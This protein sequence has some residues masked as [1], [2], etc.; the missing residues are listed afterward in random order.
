VESSL[1]DGLPNRAAEL[2]DNHLLGFAYHEQARKSG[3][4]R[5]NQYR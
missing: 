5:Q 3:N 2:R 4:Y 1:S